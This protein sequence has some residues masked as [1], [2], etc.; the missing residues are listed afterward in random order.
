MKPTTPRL[1]THDRPPKLPRPANATVPLRD[2]GLRGPVRRWTVP[3]PFIRQI[4]RPRS[5]ILE[6][7]RTTTT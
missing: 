3:Q 5:L 1:I 6:T 7:W 4:Y 2:A